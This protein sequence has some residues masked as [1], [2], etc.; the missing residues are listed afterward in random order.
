MANYYYFFNNVESSNFFDLFFVHIKRR[1][2][3]TINFALKSCAFSC[4]SAVNHVTG[5]TVII[6]IIMFEN[7]QF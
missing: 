4:S 2:K 7:K 1:K 5:A 3:L 6:I